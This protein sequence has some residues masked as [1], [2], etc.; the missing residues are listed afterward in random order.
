MAMLARVLRGPS[1]RWALALLVEYL[2]AVRRTVPEGLRQALE[3]GLGREGREAYMT[4]AQKLIDQGRE[5]GRAEGQAEMLL[6]LVAAR[7]GDPPSPVEARVRAASPEQVARWAERLLRA[8][9]L[10][11]VFADE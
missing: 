4:A 7:F 6:R 10:G 9:S 1:G 5:L 11:E 3:T 2:F 8:A